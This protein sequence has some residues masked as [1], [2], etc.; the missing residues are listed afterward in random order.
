MSTFLR[1]VA[2]L[3]IS[4][5]IDAI[6]FAAPAGTPCADLASLTISDVSVSAATDMPAGPFRLP[7][8]RADA[9]P[10]TVP[11][12]CRVVAVATPTPDSHINFE[13]WIPQGDAWNG[14]FQGVGTG[15]FQG[16][17]SYAALAAGVNRGYATASTDNRPH[18]RRP[19]ERPSRENR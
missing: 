5:A 9:A 18:G 19:W 11:A 16:S 6:A 15:G 2:A 3:S 14:K 10:A 7:G 13:V 8:A 17:I 1:L 12:F 4:I